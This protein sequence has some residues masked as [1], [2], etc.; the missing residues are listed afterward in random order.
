MSPAAPVWQRGDTMKWRCGFLAALVLVAPV[1]AV[2]DKVDWPAYLKG[3]DQLWMRM[4]KAWWEA[5][6]VGDGD[7]GLPLP[8]RR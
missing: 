6:F 7:R 1:L 4:G 3:H 5:P 2:E 8:M